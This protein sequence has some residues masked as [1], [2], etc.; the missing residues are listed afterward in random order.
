VI[1]RIKPFEVEKIP[2]ESYI[3]VLSEGIIF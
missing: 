1:I 2:S 3:Q